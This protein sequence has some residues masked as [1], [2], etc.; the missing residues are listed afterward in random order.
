MPSRFEKFLSSGIILLTQS[1]NFALHMICPLDP[2]LQGIEQ[3]HQ[4][5]QIR[6]T[7]PRAPRGRGDKEVELA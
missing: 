5:Q 3:A 7:K 2:L 4:I 1:A 6:H